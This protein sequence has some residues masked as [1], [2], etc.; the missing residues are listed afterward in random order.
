[1]REYRREEKGKGNREKEFSIGRRADNRDE[2]EEK[3]EES[4][5]FE[6]IQLKVRMYN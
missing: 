6:E 5:G 3:G 4:T 2:R 1:M